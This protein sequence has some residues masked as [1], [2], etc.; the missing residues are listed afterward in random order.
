LG[1]PAHLES[2]L[3]HQDRFGNNGTESTALTKPDDGDDRMQ[4]ES[5]NVAHAS[6]GIKGKKLR[7]HGTRGIRHQQAISAG[8]HGAR[9][10]QAQ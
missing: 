2:V 4:K 5:E 7:I 1:A 8:H 10:L 9:R 3:S 6:D